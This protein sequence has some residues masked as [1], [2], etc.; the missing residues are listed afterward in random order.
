MAWL[1]LF[2][3]GPWEFPIMLILLIGAGL[4]RMFAYGSS[5]GGGGLFG[6]LVGGGDGFGDARNW[7]PSQRGKSG[8]S[9]LP[10]SKKATGGPV[11]QALDNHTGELTAQDLDQDE[12]QSRRA[13]PQMPLSQHEELELL[14]ERRFRLRQRLPQIAQQMHSQW[15][16][17]ADS[18]QWLETASRAAPGSWTAPTPAAGERTQGERQWES[19]HAGPLQIGAAELARH[20]EVD[21]NH[22]GIPDHLELERGQT[23][24]P[25]SF[26]ERA[27][28]S[29]LE[30]EQGPAILLSGIRE[31]MLELFSAQALMGYPLRLQGPIEETRA[32]LLRAFA[33][34]DERVESEEREGL[35][36]EVLEF[37]RRDLPRMRANL[38]RASQESE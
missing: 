4:L 34:C 20:D 10:A 15:E 37:L 1:M 22:N 13:G 36:T 18:L 6:W 9:S 16:A 5:L 21:R 27:W 19:I 29:V 2:A 28:R 24:T 30:A 17:L 8:S 14:R 12:R 25:L 33:A 23:W 7:R 26:S 38:A 11:R 31:Q 3:T 32:V 35:R